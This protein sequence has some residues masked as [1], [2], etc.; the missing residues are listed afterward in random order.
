MKRIEIIVIMLLTVF[1]MVG[2][3]SKQEE[4]PRTVE[5][6]SVTPENETY[7]EAVERLHA[8]LETSVPDYPYQVEARDKAIGELQKYVREKGYQER[9]NKGNVDW[10][11]ILVILKIAGA[12]ALIYIVYL[13]FVLKKDI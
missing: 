6:L 2:C 8:M 3:S 12:V 5:E 7:E 1:F 13:K 11:T 10:D 4:K 9:R